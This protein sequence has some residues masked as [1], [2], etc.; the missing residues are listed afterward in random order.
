MRSNPLPHHDQ[1]K[2]YRRIKLA[3]V[4]AKIVFVGTLSMNDGRRLITT[5][6]K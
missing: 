3:V 1:A 5:L 4:R 2:A 6:N